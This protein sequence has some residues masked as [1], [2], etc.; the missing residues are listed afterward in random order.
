[1]Y[2]LEEVLVSTL[3]KD[4]LVN[5]RQSSRIKAEQS[6]LNPVQQSR[7]AHRWILIGTSALD[8][9]DWLKGQPASRVHQL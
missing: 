4:R 5:W 7:G 8:V 3:L 1:M 9:H 6:A 2:L